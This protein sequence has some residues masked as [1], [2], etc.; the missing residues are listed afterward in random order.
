MI[1]KIFCDNHIRYIGKFKDKCSVP[2]YYN[3]NT[4]E[5]DIAHLSRF[6]ENVDQICEDLDKNKGLK[7]SVVCIGHGSIFTYVVHNSI[8]ITS[9][10]IE[11]LKKLKKLTNSTLVERLEEVR[12]YSA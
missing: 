6:R 2:N 9:L 1:D 12:Y 10:K 4:F 5:V 3:Y 7:L 11:R 8:K